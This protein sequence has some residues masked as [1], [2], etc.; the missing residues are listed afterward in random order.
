MDDS[1]KVEVNGKTYYYIPAVCV[2]ADVEFQRECFLG[3]SMMIEGDGWGTA[4]P[5]FALCSPGKPDRIGTA[6]GCQ[7]IM[8]VLRAL[9]VNGYSDVKRRPIDVLYDTPS[10]LGTTWKGFRCRKMHG[11]S[12]KWVVFKDVI[13]PTTGKSPTS[14]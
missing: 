9:G 3:V 11:G 6:Y 5:G 12:G 10:A 14:D 7:F 4:G 1:V 2:S 13:D 8:D